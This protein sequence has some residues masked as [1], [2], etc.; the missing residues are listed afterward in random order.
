MLPG[1]YLNS[2]LNLVKLK[3]TKSTQKFVAFIYTNNEISERKFKK[4]PIYHDIKNNKIG[5]N[6]PGASPVAQQ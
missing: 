5:I 1:N 3:A 2:S 4:N 6:L